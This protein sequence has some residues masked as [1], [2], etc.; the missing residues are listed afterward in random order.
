MPWCV[1]GLLRSDL[2]REKGGRSH[3][4]LEPQ[5]VFDRT[6][7]YPQHATVVNR[8]IG[9]G[10]KDGNFGGTTST[11]VPHIS[12]RRPHRRSASGNP[13]GGN[14]LLGFKS[15]F[16][17]LVEVDTATLTSVEKER[18]EYFLGPD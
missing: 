2:E 12:R 6:Y 3:S 17:T 1:N 18:R 14:G 16:A 13:L 7:G 15:A 10:E 9:L 4:Y 8:Y 5:G 11:E